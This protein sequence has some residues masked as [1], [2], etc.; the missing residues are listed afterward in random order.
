M[1]EIDAG[2]WES[3]GRLLEDRFSK[4]I[5]TSEDSIRYCF[6]HTLVCSRSVCSPNE[7]VLEYQHP[8]IPKAQIDTCVRLGKDG[9]D[10]SIEFKFHKKPENVKNSPRTMK[11]GQLFNDFFR[12]AEFKKTYNRTVCYVVYVTD[13]EMQRY[14]SKSSICKTWHNLIVGEQLELNE[15]YFEGI[16]PTFR[17]EMKTVVPCIIKRTTKHQIDSEH[18]LIVDEITSAVCHRNSDMY[19]SDNSPLQKKNNQNKDA[20]QDRNLYASNSRED[21]VTAA[22]AVWIATA[23]LH[24]QHPSNGVFS[25]KEIFLRVQEQN[26]F[27]KYD[28]TI[29]THISSHCVANNKAQPDD[30]RKIYR[31]SRGKYRLYRSGDDYDD[32]R[33]DGKAEPS[34][35]ELP[36]K[37]KKLLDWYRNEYCKK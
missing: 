23:T 12:Q 9:P 15:E 2:V 27:H 26:L 13:V 18:M 7:I 11:A 16:P 3:L 1:E 20:S 24:K 34:V 36:D 29:K 31:V 5:H 32:T 35:Y 21:G 22:I 10:Y 4:K 33:K 19:A 14:F 25:K 37:Y 17:N 28:S 8:S 6:F 30:H